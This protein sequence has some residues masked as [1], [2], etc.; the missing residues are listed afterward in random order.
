MSETAFLNA[1]PDLFS[2]KINNVSCAFSVPHLLLQIAVMNE[3]LS[4]GKKKIQHCDR[5]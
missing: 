5:T 3:V 2:S 4:F 1:E